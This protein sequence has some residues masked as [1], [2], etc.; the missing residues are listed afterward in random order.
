MPPYE[1]RTYQ[2]APG[3]LPIVEAIFRDAV[4]PMLP[5]YGIKAIGFWA[6]LDDAQ[7]FYVVEHESE[8]VVEENW[9]R[10]HADPRWQPALDAH[11]QGR[12]AVTHTDSIHLRAFTSLLPPQDGAAC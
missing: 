9:N 1:L 2:I 7:L 12:T 8:D 11:Q 10:F 6:S 5:D 3:A 4:V